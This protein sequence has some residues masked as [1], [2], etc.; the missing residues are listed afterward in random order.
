MSR[1]EATCYGLEC[2]TN[3]GQKIGRH[4]P[5]TELEALEIICD[6]DQRCVDD[7]DFNRNDE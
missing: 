7:G 3:V 6:S 4:N 1:Y 2:V 5:T